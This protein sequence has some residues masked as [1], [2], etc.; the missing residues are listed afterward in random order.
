M[1]LTENFAQ[2]CCKVDDLLI[3]LYSPDSGKIYEFG[4]ENLVDLEIRNG[5]SI[6]RDGFVL[7]E[8]PY[9]VASLVDS[10]KNLW[11][12]IFYAENEGKNSFKGDFRVLNT[13]KIN[14]NNKSLIQFELQ[15]SL[16][17]IFSKTHKPSYQLSL[18][19]C[20][21]EYYNEFFMGDKN[22]IPPVIA[23]IS[24][25]RNPYTIDA[26]GDSTEPFNIPL[27]NFLSAF[28]K[29]LD[30]EGFICI[31]ENNVLRLCKAENISQLQTSTIPIYKRLSQ[32]FSNSP[33]YLYYSKFSEAQVSDNLP[34]SNH[35]SI[36]FE[37][38]KIKIQ[39]QNLEDIGESKETQDSNG[40]N[41][42]YS[43][44]GNTS[45]LY[46][47]TY[48][49]FLNNYNGYIVIP[50]RKSNIRIL[51]K[52]SLEAYN[53]S[54]NSKI[55]ESGDLKYSGEYIVTGYT[56]KIVNRNKLVTCARVC[57]FDNTKS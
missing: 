13:S 29:Q 4:F 11:M 21:Q 15:D 54:N 43:E 18:M 32:A 56:N 27:E 5:I 33:N 55:A 8:D 36:D 48:F 57:R 50:G 51:N 7:L 22:W 25:F 35:Y 46:M 40:F 39:S 1:N 45:N 52:I 24:T 38:K 2:E 28:S 47:Q 16:S 42:A 37:T 17:Y 10:N 49:N 23:G 34:K 53:T 44:T 31:N 14:T 20:L 6:V 41:L 30:K 3:A 9:D 19:Q 12:Y 26:K